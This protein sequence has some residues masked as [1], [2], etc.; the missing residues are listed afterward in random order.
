[1]IQTEID[2]YG[3][4]EDQYIQENNELIGDF[5]NRLQYQLSRINK[6]ITEEDYYVKFVAQFLNIPDMNPVYDRS[7]LIDSRINSYEK[8]AFREFIFTLNRYIENSLGIEFSE[9]DV[10]IT[11]YVYRV[12][13][14]N[15]IEYFLEYIDGLQKV[16]INW[17][18]DIE[19]WDQVSFTAFRKKRE[20][21]LDTPITIQLVSDYL[22]YVIFDCLIPEHYFEVCLLGSEGNVELSEL[23][24]ES[25][26]QRISYDS[27]FIRMRFEKIFSSENEIRDTIVNG[28][29]SILN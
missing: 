16:D 5:L 12:L 1:M 23:V 29:V 7:I 14:V 15:F 20:I 8:E 6:P 3:A 19:N 11:Y 4:S 17:D 9:V 25:V 10:C 26:N 24:V 18:E 28:M 13:V 2:E 27:E 21:P 22:D